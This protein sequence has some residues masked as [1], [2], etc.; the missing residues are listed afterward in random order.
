MKP[1]KRNSTKRQRGDALLESL[2]A[3]ALLGIIGLGLCYALGRAMVAQKYQK[4]QSL[5]VQAVRSTLQSQGVASA[6]PTSGS[7]SSTQSI[8]LSLSDSISLSNVQKSC[9]IAAVTV[10]VNGVTKT[11]QLPLVRYAV[12]AQTLLG[13]G[14]LMLGNQ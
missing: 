4:A 7:N 8:S 10:S 12:D 13:P 9:T 2:V 1:A 14:T 11:A 5:T 3:V 6:C